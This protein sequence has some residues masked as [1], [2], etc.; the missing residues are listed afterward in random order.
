MEAAGVTRARRQ[1]SLAQLGDRTGLPGD[2]LARTSRLVA[3]VDSAAVQDGFELYLHNFV[4]AADGRWVVVQ[5][6]MNTGERLARRYHWHSEQAGD[7]VEEPHVAIEGENVGEI[8]NLTDRRA[9]LARAAQLELVARGPDGIVGALA[10]LRGRAVTPPLPHL[11]LPEH[12]EVLASDV[13]LRRLHGTLAAVADTGPADFAELLL[14]RGV[15]ARTLLSVALVAEVV[16]GADCRF[17]DPGRF[18]L[19]LGGKDGH[20]FPVPLE[21]Y[22]RTIGVLRAALESSRLGNDERLAAI[23]RLDRQARLAEAWAEGPSHEEFVREERRRSRGYGGR[24]VFDDRVD[25]AGASRSSSR[26]RAGSRVRSG[27]GTSRRVEKRG[28]QLDLF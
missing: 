15:G 14:Q 23:Q 7:L 6:G 17:E 5:Q 4:V 10:R 2:Q 3:K 24:S 12:H 26:G 25:R 28:S 9:D 21:V 18:S 19:A 20:P 13:D 27:S 8:V 11:D 16:H 22:D 1:W